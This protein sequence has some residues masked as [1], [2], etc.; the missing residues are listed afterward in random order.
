MPRIRARLAVAAAPGVGSAVDAPLSSRPP[1]RRS[2]RAASSRR[3]RIVSR[4]SMAHSPL[5]CSLRSHTP[6]GRRAP[7]WRGQARPSR[8]ACSLPSPGS[9]SRAGREGRRPEPRRAAARRAG[10]MADEEMLHDGMMEEDEGE[11]AIT[12]ARRRRPPAASD[13]AADTSALRAAAAQEDSWQVISS[14]FEAKG[15]VRQQLVRCRR[16]CPSRRRLQRG[17]ARLPRRLAQALRSRRRVAGLFRRVHSEHHAGNRRQVSHPRSRVRMQRDA[18]CRTRRARRA[19]RVSSALSVLRQTQGL[20][21]ARICAP[22]V[23]RLRSQTSR[24]PS[25]WCLRA[26]TCR[27]RS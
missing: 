4:S 15:L 12:Q 20:R 8:A 25:S 9:P 23:T 19:A 6:S 14:F 10:S 11:M 7:L 5:R 13:A 22:C 17:T 18:C 3:L 1:P 24:R 16:R 2:L 27:G 21:V 26:S